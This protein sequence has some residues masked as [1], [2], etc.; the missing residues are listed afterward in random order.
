MFSQVKFTYNT[1]QFY[2][3][4]YLCDKPLLTSVFIGICMHLIL[5]KASKF[6]GDIGKN[7][8]RQILTNMLSSIAGGGSDL[9][10]RI[11][12][13]TEHSIEISP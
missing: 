4:C 7:E 8:K 9:L 2:S 12:K 5:C 3:K 10:N 13:L 6:Q 11:P 1:F